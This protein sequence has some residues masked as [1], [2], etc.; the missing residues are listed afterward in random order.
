MY[1]QAHPYPRADH[2][3]PSKAKNITLW[4]LQILLTVAFVLAALA[5][6]TGQP[7]MVEVFDR[8]G[9]GQWFRYLTAAIELASAAMLLSV[10]TA[11]VGAALLVCTMIGAVF[12]HATR[13]G[14]NPGPAIVLGVLAA[15]VL[16]GRFDQLR[17][18]TAD[19]STSA[20]HARSPA[21]P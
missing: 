7:M 5:K 8:V 13:L 14:G 9:F 15:I 11:P 10:S 3:V 18:L 12:A 1:A 4:T 19:G 2:P 20:F 16:W 21:A 17:A 6:F